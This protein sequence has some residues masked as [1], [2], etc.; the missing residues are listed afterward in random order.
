MFTAIQGLVEAVRQDSLGIGYN[1]I[2]YAY[3]NSTRKQVDGIIIVPI[4]IDGNGII[5][6]T[7]SFY[8][9]KSDIL[10][11]ISLNIYPSPPARGLNLVTK[12]AFTGA[13]KD[14]IYW[15]LTDGQKFVEQAG[16]VPLT[17]EKLNEQLKKLQG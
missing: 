6:A 7:E 1:N 12:N 2:G 10:K 15:I 8:E 17:Q 11:A 4:D 14:F 16:Y 13:T 9:S 5:N 3:D